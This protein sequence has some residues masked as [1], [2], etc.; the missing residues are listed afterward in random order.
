MW[1]CGLPR[2]DRTA[3]TTKFPTLVSPL[4]CTQDGQPQ[5]SV[6]GHRS[7][8]GP[9]AVP[10]P[11]HNAL[12]NRCPPA[13]QCHRSFANHLAHASTKFLLK[14][15]Y[16]GRRRCM[17]RRRL[18]HLNAGQPHTTAGDRVRV[19]VSSLSLSSQTPLSPALSLT[20]WSSRLA[21]QTRSQP[22]SLQ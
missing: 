3:S 11:L 22:P 16:D 18:W 21:C 10:S 2:A 4:S 14:R 13:V 15:R 8:H 19:S 20:V 7:I 9:N 5:Q 12:I 17:L 1:V 6:S